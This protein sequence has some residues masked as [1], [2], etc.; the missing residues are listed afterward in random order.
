VAFYWLDI[1]P[2]HRSVGARFIEVRA[3]LNPSAVA[4]SRDLL[5]NAPWSYALPNAS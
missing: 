2:L 4:H 1:L 3:C 5:L